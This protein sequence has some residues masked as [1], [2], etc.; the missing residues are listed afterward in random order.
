MSRA[1]LRVDAARNNAGSLPE[2][3]RAS[4]LARATLSPNVFKSGPADRV[5]VS[6]FQ[7]HRS[8]ELRPTNRGS[9]P[10]RSYRAAISGMNAPAKTNS[11]AGPPGP[12]G[13]S[14]TTPR[15]RAGSVAFIRAS[16]TVIRRP[17]GWR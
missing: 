5:N 10:T 15:R 13:L 4:S 12:P 17:R 9:M 8:G 14:S 7:S 1:V 2:Q 16:A 11:L 3:P 6:V